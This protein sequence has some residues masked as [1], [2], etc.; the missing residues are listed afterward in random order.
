MAQ[1]PTTILLAIDGSADAQLAE[2]V[3]VELS[4]RSGAALHVVHA[5][6]YVPVGPYPYSGITATETYRVFE[7]GAKAILAESVERITQ[8]GGIVT[9]QYLRLGAPADTIVALSEEIDTDLLIIGSRGLGPI[10]RLALGSVSTSVIHNVRRPTL[11]VRGDKDSWPPAQIIVGND[12]SADGTRA[13]EL[14]A[15]FGR[16]YGAKLTLARAVP[17]PPDV[18]W[19]NEGQRASIEKLQEELVT[20]ARDTLMTDARQLASE[21]GTAPEVTI[22]AGDPAAILLDSAAAQTQPTLIVVGCRGLGLLD[23]LRLGSVS[24]KVVHAAQGPIFVVPHRAD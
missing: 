24:T 20:C 2:H 15:A 14:A 4:G 5:W 12:G 23:R 19:Y 9:K 17:E 8:A 10:R 1:Y 16:L 18:R 21:A 22:A 13:A 6:L 11:L 3:A 7:E